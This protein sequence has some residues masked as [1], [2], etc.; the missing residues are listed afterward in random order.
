MLSALVALGMSLQLLQ[1]DSMTGK[2]M[3]DT[4]AMASDMGAAGTSDCHACGKDG[5]G[6]KMMTCGSIC[7]TSVAALLPEGLP[8]AFSFTLD[9]IAPPTPQLLMGRLTAPEPF[10]PRSIDLA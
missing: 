2:A 9:R 7:A 1:T 3:P 6:V 10:P 8:M 5:G 4:M